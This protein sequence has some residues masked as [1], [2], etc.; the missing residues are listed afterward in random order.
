MFSDLADDSNAPVAASA[1]RT[2]LAVIDATRATTN[3][4]PP[5]RPR[6]VTRP[7]STGVSPVAETIEPGPCALLEL[8]INLVA[9]VIAPV[10]GHALAEK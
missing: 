3:T 9:K 8:R 4:L 6:D 10:S 1:L 7:C 5:P 2:A